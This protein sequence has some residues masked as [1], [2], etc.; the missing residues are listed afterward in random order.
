[1]ITGHAFLRPAKAFG[2]DPEHNWWLTMRPLPLQPWQPPQN[3]E[4]S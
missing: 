2:T 3:E 4:Q 1:L